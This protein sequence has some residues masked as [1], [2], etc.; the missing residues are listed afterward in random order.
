MSYVDKERSVI[1]ILLKTTDR[2][3]DVISITSA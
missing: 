2:R 3:Y 1:S